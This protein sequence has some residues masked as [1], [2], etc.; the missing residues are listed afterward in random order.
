M[1]EFEADIL[2]KLRQETAGGGLA[3]PISRAARGDRTQAN[4]GVGKFRRA[5]RPTGRFMPGRRD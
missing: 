2:L 1:E 5:R 3:R 4:D